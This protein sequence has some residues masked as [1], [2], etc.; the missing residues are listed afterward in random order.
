M[1]IVL[2]QLGAQPAQRTDDSLRAGGFTVE[3]VETVDQGIARA[4]RG[5]LDVVLLDVAAASADSLE[6][7][8]EMRRR[9]AAV[10]I[11][12]LSA[13]KTLDACV[14]ALDS[15]ADDYLVK[16]FVPAELVSRIV[17][18]ARRAVAPRWNPSSNV[19]VTIRE[20][21]VVEFCDRSVTLSPRQHALLS[22][23]MRRCGDVVSRLEILIEAFGYED[24][25]GT[26]VVAVHLVHLREKLQGFPI[27]IETVRGAG[28]RL[29][30]VTDACDARPPWR[31]QRRR[32]RH[33]RSRASRSDPRSYALRAP[34]GG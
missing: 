15:G 5:E 20:D 31:E 33:D 3:V 29:K 25:T 34:F 32:T 28:I 8:R 2:V 9:A 13:D 10:P 16:P 4:L 19:P 6:V 23:L 22:F 21:R 18:L 11:L 12:M 7:V 27:T 17:A 24:D 26:N 30:V 14:A 1:H